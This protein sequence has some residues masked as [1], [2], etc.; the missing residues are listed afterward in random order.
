MW[1]G[2]EARGAE[3]M[4]L[5]FLIF[6]EGDTDKSLSLQTGTRTLRTRTVTQTR[7]SISPYWLVG[8][9][10]GWGQQAHVWISFS[11]SLALH[12]SLS[13]S[14]PA[15]LHQGAE[16]HPELCSLPSPY[17]ANLPHTKP[18]AGVPHLVV[19]SLARVSLPFTWHT[20]INQSV[21]FHRERGLMDIPLSR[22]PDK[23]TVQL[24]SKMGDVVI[25][26]DLIW[27]HFQLSVQKGDGRQHQWKQNQ[28]EKASSSLSSPWNVVNTV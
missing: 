18:H 3:V 15:F 4:S 10:K 12:L 23:V 20:L 1:R 16:L 21:A 24:C 27:I 5:G 26:V 6:I 8:G 19:S 7:T 11:L 22:R 25:T 9:K 13:D 2:W 14:I 17:T 28:K